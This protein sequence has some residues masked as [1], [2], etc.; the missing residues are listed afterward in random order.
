MA[1]LKALDFIKFAL[2]I[3]FLTVLSNSYLVSFT[4]P[5][6]LTLNSV[7]KAQEVLLNDCHSI[8]LRE[9]G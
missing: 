1:S 7:M 4:S 3:A 8:P 9:I 5:V 2:S 6:F